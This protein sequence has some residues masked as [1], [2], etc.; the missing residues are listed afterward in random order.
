[1]FSTLPGGLFGALFAERP[2]IPLT[3]LKTAPVR[4]AFVAGKSFV[5]MRYDNEFSVLPRFPRNLLLRIGMKGPPELRRSINN[6]RPSVVWYDTGA[7][8]FEYLRYEKHMFFAGLPEP[9]HQR[10]VTHF[11]GVTRNRLNPADVHGAGDFAR[12]ESVV[13]ERLRSSYGEV[14]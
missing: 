12:V 10:F 2:W 5:A 9:V 3:L 8:V 14:A 6:S 1:M 7:Q 4:D 13:R 11:F